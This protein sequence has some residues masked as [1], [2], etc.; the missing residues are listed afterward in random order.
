MHFKD[1]L[2]LYYH[3]NSIFLA[4]QQLKHDRI[5]QKKFNQTLD[6]KQQIW[7]EVTNK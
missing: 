6:T 2:D 3:S 5:K 4:Q 1:Y 7:F